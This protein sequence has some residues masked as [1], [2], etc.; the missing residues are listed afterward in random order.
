MRLE[1]KV[2]I[3]TG[4]GGGIGYAYAERFLREGARVVIAE[5]HE[6][7]AADAA[8]TL[9]ALGEVHVVAT[10]VASETSTARAA[11]DAADH[12]GGIDVL[13]N[14][15]AIYGDWNPADQSFEYLRRVMD[16]NLYGV[17]LMT[18]AVAPFMVERGGGRVINQSSGAAYNYTP[19]VAESFEGL[20]SYN[21]AMS[22][23]GVVGLTKYMAAQLGQWH[24]T[25]NCIAPGVIDTEATRSVIDSS[26]LATLAQRQAVRGQLTPEHLTGAAVFFA[27]DEAEFI[28]GQVL[29]VD[30]GKH[31]PA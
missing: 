7:R 28:T 20:N 1:G 11:Q 25:V 3:V 5:L 30:G 13:V 8:A 24:I 22:K 29:V 19:T 6:Q 26:I 9:K 12:F 31:M 18:K 4:A 27:S 17:W 14:N 15:A 23:W 21:Y 2:A 10:D 16:V